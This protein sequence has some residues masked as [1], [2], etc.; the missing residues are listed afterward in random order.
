MTYVV[1]L[2]F[3]CGCQETR[4]DVPDRVRD[5]LWLETLQQSDCPKGLHGSTRLAEMK[6]R[7]Q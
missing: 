4:R 2:S 5:I 6:A 7:G 3:A 1:K